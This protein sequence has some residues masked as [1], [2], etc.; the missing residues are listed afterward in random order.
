M[1][2]RWLAGKWGKAPHPICAPSGCAKALSATF[3][4]MASAG[5]SGADDEQVHQ[6]NRRWTLLEQER[7]KGE[8]DEATYRR[9]IHSIFTFDTVETFWRLWNNY[10]K[11]SCA[12]AAPAWAGRAAR[13]VLLAL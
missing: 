6:L 8:P 11:P 7:C 2:C 13:S 4:F 5:S 9:N 12:R 10:P 1:R 3:P